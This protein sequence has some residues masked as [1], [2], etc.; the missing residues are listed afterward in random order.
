LGYEPE[1][2]TALVDVLVEPRPVDVPDSR[3]TSDPLDDPLLHDIAPT[4]DLIAEL[5]GLDSSD[6]G[7]TPWRP[8][9]VDEDLIGTDRPRWRRRALVAVAALAVGWVA[10]GYLGGGPDPTARVAENAASLST[11]VAQLEPLAEDL[12]DGAFESPLDVGSTLG[13]VDRTARALFS[14]AAELDQESPDASQLRIT[15][16]DL[17]TLALTVESALADLAAYGSGVERITTPLALPTTAA[18]ADLPE[19]TARLSEWI[20]TQSDEI[21]MLPRNQLTSDHRTAVETF[22]DGLADWQANYLDAVRAGTAADAERLVLELDTSLQDLRTG[23]EMTATSS[24]QWVSEQLVDLRN[25]AAAIT[26]V[27]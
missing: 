12:A 2:P 1:A 3:I 27:P 25:R 15:S 6:G 4:G 7:S 19:L 9:D 8:A 22:G 16:S 10:G 18:A 17:A 23:W 11:A 21:D 24:A 5:W 26:P 13:E 20:T 14:S